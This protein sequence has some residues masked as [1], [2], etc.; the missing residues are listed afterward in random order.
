VHEHHFTLVEYDAQR[1]WIVRRQERHSVE[2]ADGQDFA[3]SAADQR[4]HGR[5]EIRP[6][7]QLKPWPRPDVLLAALVAQ[8]A[9]AAGTTPMPATATPQ[10]SGL[11]VSARVSARPPHQPLGSRPDRVGVKLTIARSDAGFLSRQRRG[12]QCAAG[13]ARH[14]WVTEPATLAD[15]QAAQKPPSTGALARSV[16]PTRCANQLARLAGASRAKQHPGGD[17]GRSHVPATPRSPRR[18]RHP[19]THH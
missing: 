19:S 15:A 16:S 1:P 14:A 5:Y 10:R 3:E 13:L 7:P 4:P 8:T 17:R 6:D 2:L 12:A 11:S 18:H 9:R